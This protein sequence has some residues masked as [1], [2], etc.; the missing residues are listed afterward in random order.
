MR[1]FGAFIG[2]LTG[3]A[4]HPLGLRVKVLTS[5]EEEDTYTYV[6]YSDSLRLRVKASKVCALIYLPCMP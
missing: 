6:V 3:L 1:A 5:G 4:G 2:D